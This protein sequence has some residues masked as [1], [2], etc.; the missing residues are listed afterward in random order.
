MR[1]ALSSKLIRTCFEGVSALHFKKGAQRV[2]ICHRHPRRGRLRP[3]RAVL[4]LEDDLR[5]LVDSCPV[6]ICEFPNL[7]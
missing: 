5:I 6:D 3:D 1:R 7:N 4:H 2:W